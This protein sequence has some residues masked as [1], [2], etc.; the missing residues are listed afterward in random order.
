MQRSE[1]FPSITSSEAIQISF[2]VRS[3]F[4]IRNVAGGLLPILGVMPFWPERHRVVL[5]ELTEWWEDLCQRGI[6]SQVVFVPVPFGWGRSTVLEEFRAVVEDVN[7]PITVVVTIDGDLPPG[8]AVQADALWEA[9]AAAGR[10]SR[11]ADLLD[12]DT[13]LGRVQMGLGVG[14]LFVSGLA[15]AASVLIASLTMTAAGNAW[16]TSPAGQAGAVARA[17]RAVAAV[18]VSVP[19]VVIIDDADV[20]D[21]DLAVTLIRNLAARGDGQVLV[22]AAAAPDSSLVRALASRPGNGLAGR[23]HRA[24]ADPDM[25]Y[26]E[27][28]DLAAELLPGLPAAAA[29]RIAQRTRTVGEVFAVTSGGRLA[30]LTETSDT[31]T[32]IAVVDVVAADKLAR[33]EPSSAA[34]VLAWA[35]GALHAAQL[36]RALAVSKT[37]LAPDGLEFGLNSDPWVTRAGELVRLAGPS[38]TRL[39][40]KVAALPVPTRHELAAAVLSAAVHLGASPEAGVIERVVGRQ[41]VH[42]IRADL[43]DRAGLADVQCALIRGLEQLGDPAAA[44]QIATT[45]L[46][47]SKRRPRSSA[48]SVCRRSPRRAPRLRL[49]RC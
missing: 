41:A 17:A 28:A 2:A 38:D 9:L 47:S 30:E 31:A 20:L 43:D 27:R 29:K 23:V 37:D 49:L 25:G 34:V 19:V 5:E 36:D 42:H 13:A 10:R 21:L 3:V 12:L 18:S 6:G 14:G 7:G 45:A 22:V 44:R 16:D 1:S 24:E 40:E 35:G 11:V 48:T 15:A 4:D 26:R 46:E 39:V 32:I 33:L 8:R